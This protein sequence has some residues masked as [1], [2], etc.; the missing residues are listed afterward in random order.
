MYKDRGNYTNRPI[1]P[2]VQITILM[3]MCTFDRCVILLELNIVCGHNARSSDDD[4]IIAN[5]LPNIH[6]SKTPKNIEM[7]VCT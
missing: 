3:L 5:S 1:Q 7:V 4:N 6:L 2:H